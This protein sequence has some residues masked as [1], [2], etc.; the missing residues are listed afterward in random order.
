MLSFNKTTRVRPLPMH[1]YLKKVWG[2]RPRTASMPQY[3]PGANVHL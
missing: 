3:T 1:S 2:D